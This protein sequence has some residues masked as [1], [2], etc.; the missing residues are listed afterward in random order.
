MDPVTAYSNPISAFN[1]YWYANNNPYRFIDPD[2]RETK[3]AQ[4]NRSWI[5]IEQEVGDSNNL[6]FTPAIV[7]KREAALDQALP[8]LFSTP[9]GQEMKQAIIDSGKLLTINLNNENINQSPLN[10]HEINIDPGHPRAGGVLTTGVRTG[11]TEGIRE[12][13]LTAVIGHEVGHAVFGDQD[14][15]PGNMDNVNKNEN[16]VRRSIG[17][18]ERTDYQERQP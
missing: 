15:G 13:S 16:P 17:E 10:S 18:P 7:A 14:A 5:K 11:T 12:A 3:F 6:A 4:E 2:G 9:R 8:Q 1:R